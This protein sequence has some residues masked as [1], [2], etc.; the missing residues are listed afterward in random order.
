MPAP[1]LLA[2]L[3]PARHDLVNH[4]VRHGRVGH[5]DEVPVGVVVYLFDGLARMPRKDAVQHIARAQYLL[6]VEVEVDCLALRPPA[7]LVEQDARVG[8]R[9]T[10]ALGPR[11]QE[12]RGAAGRLPDAPGGY[13]AGEVHHGVVDRQRAGDH[14]ARR[15]DVDVDVL[16]GVLA[17]EEQQLRHDQVGEVVLDLLTYE[18]DALLEQARVDVVLPLAPRGLLDDY[19]YQLRPCVI[20]CYSGSSPVLV[21]P[22]SSSASALSSA[23]ASSAAVSVLLSSGSAVGSPS[24]CPSSTPTASASPSPPTRVAF[25][26]SRSTALESLRLAFTFCIL[27]CL[28]ASAMTFL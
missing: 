18:Q 15:V 4:A 19:R 2:L 10:L 23:T 11:R 24:T 1:R 22:V 28:R 14:T 25:S 17:L 12:H 27:P 3:D 26:T 5:H 16:L 21:A 13:V 7:G 6:G 9:E 20:H 8:R